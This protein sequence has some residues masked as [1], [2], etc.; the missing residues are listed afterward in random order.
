MPQLVRGSIGQ[1]GDTDVYRFIGKAGD[2]VVAEV[3]ARRLGSPM[4]PLL[5]VTDAAGRV[6]AWN[7]DYE[8]GD[9]GLVTHQAD[10]YLSLKLPAD[11]AYFV[12][13]SDAQRHGG[14]DCNYYLRVAPPQADFTLRATPSNVNIPPGG[15][16]SLTVYAFRKDGWNGD[17]QVTLKDAPRG[18]VLAGG[19][20]PAGQDH[21]EMTLTVPRGTLGESFSLQLEGRAQI[22]GTTVTRPVVPAER[23]MQAF[24][25]Y[26]LVPVQQLLVTVNRR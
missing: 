15:K 2:T 9:M 24:A 1:P 10:S 13:V 16:A 4:D 3:Y 5:R 17:I 12:Q 7:D 21:A 22:D 20:I 26:H 18:F 11:G 23:K 8:N 25:T 14:D 6:L 19:R